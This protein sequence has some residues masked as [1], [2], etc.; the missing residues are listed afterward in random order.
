MQ[1]AVLCNLQVLQYRNCTIVQYHNVHLLVLSTTS[2][3]RTP[4][5]GATVQRTEVFVARSI[6]VAGCGCTSGVGR[7]SLVTQVTEMQGTADISTY[8]KDQDVT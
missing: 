3:Y 1:Y 4:I 6:D 2:I 7:V 5:P 8:N